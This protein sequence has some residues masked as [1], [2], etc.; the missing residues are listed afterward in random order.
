MLGEPFEGF[1]DSLGD[2]APAVLDEFK[3]GWQLQQTMAE[4]RQQRIAQANHRLEAACTV[5]GIGQH[6]GSID[7]DVYLANAAAMPGC[8][9]DPAFLK[10]FLKRNESC[11]V[12][13]QKKAQIVIP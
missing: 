8:W 10:E 4:I 7:M 3:T 5:D 1:V 2:L 6:I 12:T 9:N 13:T 11:R